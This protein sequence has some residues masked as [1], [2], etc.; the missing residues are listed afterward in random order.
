MGMKRGDNKKALQYLRD[1][2]EIKRSILGKEYNKE[3]PEILCDIGT[4]EKYEGNYESA[5]AIFSVVLS[6]Q[7]VNLGEF[8]IKVA[9]ILHKLGEIHVK[10]ENHVQAS[11]SFDDALIIY[12]KC[13]FDEDNVHIQ[14]ALLWKDYLKNHS[15]RKPQCNFMFSEKLTIIDHSHGYNIATYD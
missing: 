3:A 6:M 15:G 5:L 14:D 12:E 8:H 11:C 1:A 9:R 10:L 4:L 13:G 2:L 7:K